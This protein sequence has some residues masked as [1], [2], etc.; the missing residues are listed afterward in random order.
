MLFQNLLNKKYRQ[1]KPAFDRLFELAFNN[2]THLG[3]LLLVHQ[4]GFYNP[5]VY[6][7]DNIPEKL[8]PYMMDLG[9]SV[10]PNIL[11]MILSGIMLPIIYRMKIC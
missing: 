5:E 10:T 11:T 8:S 7:W 2:Q 4:N 3:D 1:L 9:K 6:E